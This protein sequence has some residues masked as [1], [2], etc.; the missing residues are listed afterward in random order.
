M[1]FKQLRV[2]SAVAEDLHFGKA[3]RHLG[4]SQST[5]SDQV[6]ALETHFGT[7]LLSRTSRSVQLTA[8]GQ[9]LLDGSKRLLDELERVENQVSA[10]AAGRQGTLRIGAVGP[11]MNYLVPHLLKELRRQSPDLE[12][13]IAS[14]STAVQ[15]RQLSQGQIDLGF[16]RSVQ[17]VR[18]VR[19]EKVLEEP[20]TA[21]LPTT[22]RH[23][24]AE[25]LEIQ[26]LD[27]ED[28]V[29]WPRI[30]N[31]DLYDVLIATCYRHGCSPRRITESQD[32][33]TQLALIASGLGVSVQPDSF[34]YAPRRDVVF[35]PLR[36]PLPKIALHMAWSPE[37]D[38]PAVKAAIAVARQFKSGQIA[39]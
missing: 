39:E 12:I 21:L 25:F 19:L 20:L 30:S 24:S 2:F 15:L 11:A 22:H 5:V 16:V 6:R 9:A 23:A 37:G 1:E 32:M 31:P 7:E 27:G 33:A 26:D 13:T 36:G 18:G 4:V 14:L 8:A 28:F 17:H 38:S 29:Y 3:A 10:V 34:R 35:V